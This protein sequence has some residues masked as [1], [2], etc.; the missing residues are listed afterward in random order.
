[1]ATSNNRKKAKRGQPARVAIVGGGCAGLAAAWHLSKQQGYEVT[2]YEKSWRLGGK[3]A[4]GRDSQG[5][6]REHGLHIWLGFYENA[7]K[8]MRECYAEV[9]ERKWGPKE[10]PGNRLAH[11]SIEDAFFPEP[12]IGVAIPDSAED[13]SLDP[14]KKWAVWSGLLPPA[15]GMP[16]EALD[17]ETN[18]FTLANY[19]LRC[20]ELLKAL[21]HS[22]VGP[23]DEPVPGKPRPEERSKLD[24]TIELNFAFDPSRSP[25]LLVEMMARYLRSGTLTTAAGLLQAVTILENWLHKLNYSPQA[26]DTALQLMEAV[27]AQT[28]KLLRDLVSVDQN[29]RRK[30]EIIDIVMTI[31]VGLYRDRVLFEEKG[32]D[33]INHIDYRDWLRQHG[34]TNTSVDSQFITGIYDLTFA[35]RDGDRNQPALAAGVALRGALRM[36]F[37]YRGSMFWLMRSGMGDA[38]FAPLYKV[39]K[40]KPRNVKFNFDHSLRDVTFRVEP[41]DKRYVTQLKFRTTGRAFPEDRVLDEFGCWPDDQPGAKRKSKSKSKNENARTIKVNEDFDAVIFAMGFDDF[42]EVFSRSKDP[43]GLRF[44]DAMPAEWREMSKQVQ[45]VATQ[46]AQVW[47]SRDLDQLGWHRGSGIITAF[48][49]P[50]ETWAD[51]THTLASEK[52]WR[53]AKQHAKVDS[54][55]AR[56]VAYFCGVLPENEIQNRGSKVGAKVKDDLRELLTRKIKPLWPAAFRNGGSAKD[57]AITE[58]FQ[59][60]FKGSDRYTLSLPGSIEHR[61]SPL[62]PSVLNMAIAG[63]WTASGLDAGCVE[64]AVMSGMLAAF[65]I[66][67]DQPALKSIVGYDHP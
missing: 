54:D 8:M 25:T 5:H 9:K 42:M 44:F 39:L 52:A 59:A 22:V 7:F 50:F 57:F 38:V 20:F 43:K 12:H 30:T 66:T 1:M 26:A 14:G 4:S 31:A 49:P 48:E 53:A 27:A 51:M 13:S 40:A 10:A 6:I 55:N 67:N 32:L 11:G 37:T 16:G 58:H 35:Y 34:A 28:R 18:P 46:A 29:M 21:M 23:P 60:N 64:S 45:T 33:A 36:F 24:E 41:G 62:D 56:S 19:L 2:V 61:I 63:D 3:G 15:K 65:A 47:L 17:E